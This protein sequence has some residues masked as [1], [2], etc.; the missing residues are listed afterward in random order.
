M[1]LKAF[2]DL[3]LQSNAW[4]PIIEPWLAYHFKLNRSSQSGLMSSAVKASKTP[5]ACCPS[6]SNPVK[7]VNSD[8]TGRSVSD[9]TFRYLGDSLLSRLEF[10]R[11]WRVMCLNFT[12]NLH[13]PVEKCEFSKYLGRL[14]YLTDVGLRANIIVR[15]CYEMLNLLTQISTALLFQ[16]Q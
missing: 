5:K 7:L 4:N 11:C 13:P 10:G 14:T 1:V 2:R 16:A 9:A 12:K 8:R 15:S 3:N 6:L